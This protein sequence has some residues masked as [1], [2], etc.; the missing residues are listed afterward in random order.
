MREQMEDS[1]TLTAELSP[2]QILVAYE[3]L[4]AGGR[5]V[6][7]FARSGLRFVDL[8][9]GVILVEQNPRKNSK[10]AALTLEGHRVAWAMKDGE[11]L[12]RIVDN[13][14]TILSCADLSPGST[15]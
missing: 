6:K 7:K 10:W 5:G 3:K 9:N 2:G 13:E 11:Y 8:T 15:T 1:K 4:F 14:V 12:A